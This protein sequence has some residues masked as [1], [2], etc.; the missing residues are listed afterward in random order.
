M[1]EVSV[2]DRAG[3]DNSREDDEELEDNAASKDDQ[4]DQAE[5]GT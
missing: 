5:D 2:A 3:V 4:S 1:E